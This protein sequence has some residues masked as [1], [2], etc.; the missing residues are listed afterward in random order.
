MRTDGTTAAEV[1]VCTAGK[2]GVREN[3]R[4]GTIHA[5]NRTELD[6]WVEVPTFGENSQ[7]DTR[8]WFALAL[9][10]SVV[11]RWSVGNA[12]LEQLCEDLTYVICKGDKFDLG[13]AREKKRKKK[14]GIHDNANRK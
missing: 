4:C 9:V 10:G 6:H 5:I 14:S 8:K 3:H 11:T 13:K 12:T 2:Q 1:L 7:K